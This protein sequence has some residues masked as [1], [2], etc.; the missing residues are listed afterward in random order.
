MFGGNANPTQL[1]LCSNCCVG[2]PPTPVPVTRDD[3]DDD[4]ND[5]GGGDTANYTCGGGGVRK[6]AHLSPNKYPNYEKRTVIYLF[7]KLLQNTRM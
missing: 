6:C 2:C 4:D 1:N 5:G 7:M 3:D